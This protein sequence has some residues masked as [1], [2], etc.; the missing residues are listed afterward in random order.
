MLLSLK[1]AYVAWFVLLIA[2]NAGNVSRM[3]GPAE[4]KRLNRTEEAMMVWC[5]VLAVFLIFRVLCG[6]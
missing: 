1:T 2:A 6:C 4:A 3:F 5:L